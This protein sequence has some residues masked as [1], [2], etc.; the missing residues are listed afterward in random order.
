MPYT[1]LQI[2]DCHLGDNHGDE[3]LGLN[4]DQSLAWVIDLIREKIPH[5]DAVI[6]SGDLTN[7]GGE[8]ALE[9]F[10]QYLTTLPLITPVYWLP[11]N[12]DDSELLTRLSAKT[13]NLENNPL[14]VPGFHLG[15]WQV[16]LFDSSIPKKVPGLLTNEELARMTETLHQQPN[17][18]HLFCMH[19]P[20]LKVGSAWIDPQRVHNAAAVIDLAEQHDH[21]K[22][23]MS[24][25][26][27]Q[28]YNQPLSDKTSARMI[29]TP[30]TSV[31]FKPNSDDFAL[32]NQMPGFRWFTLNDDGSFDTGV[33][34]ISPRVL[35][36]NHQAGGY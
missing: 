4:A 1:L 23:V 7:E 22:A 8:P 11:G 27:H 32:D 31:Q 14:F 20:L 30:S 28:A 2:S 26:V 12:H 15:P 36:I 33:E 35:N 10:K 29:A 19:H 34:R 18:H 21:L 3:L 5:Y 25:H 16:S 9:R 6:C 24:G 17:K 13:A